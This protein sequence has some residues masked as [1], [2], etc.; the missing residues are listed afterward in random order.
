LS[1]AILLSTCLNYSVNV[2]TLHKTSI[3]SASVI[4]RQAPISGFYLLPQL[5]YFFF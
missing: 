1:N 4:Q 3:I 2:R 5:L